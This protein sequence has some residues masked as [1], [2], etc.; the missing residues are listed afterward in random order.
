M[1]VCGRWRLCRSCRPKR[2]L[3]SQIAISCERGADTS[4]RCRQSAQS[5]NDASAT[6]YLGSV[7]G[8][9]SGCRLLRVKVDRCHWHKVRLGAM[10]VA[11]LL[12]AG[13]S[14]HPNRT[15]VYTD[16]SE[17]SYETLNSASTRVGRWLLNHGL[18]PGDRMA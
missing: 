8:P 2:S 11:N 9:L 17:I 13:A 18:C 12:S 4:A 5:A 3:P 10:T 14:E 15:A 6:P 7:V 16:T 1:F